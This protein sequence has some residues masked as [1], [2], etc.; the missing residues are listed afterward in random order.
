MDYTL[1]WNIHIDKVKSHISSSLFA[2]NK[3]KHFAL[4]KIWKR[5]ILFIIQWF[6]LILY[7]E[8]P[9]EVQHASQM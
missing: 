7:M 1:K 8:L 3:I 5:Y 4:Q 9:Y 6:I 2:I